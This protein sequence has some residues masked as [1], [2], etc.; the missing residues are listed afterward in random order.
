M[1]AT[2]D[3]QARRGPGE[4]GQDGATKR[5]RPTPVF[6]RPRLRLGAQGDSFDAAYESACKRT[7]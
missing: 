2:P 1:V 3:I 6:P 5:A 7:G 4:A